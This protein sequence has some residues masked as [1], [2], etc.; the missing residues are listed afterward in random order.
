M[1][2]Q[3]SPQDLLPSCSSASAW[4]CC[5]QA[6]PQSHQHPRGEE[7]ILLVQ[8]SPLK[9]PYL[10]APWRELRYLLFPV[11]WGD[12]GLFLM[13][14]LAHSCRPCE[15][16]PKST[17]CCVLQVLYRSYFRISRMAFGGEKALFKILFIV[18]PRQKGDK[19]CQTMVPGFSGSSFL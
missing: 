17:L 18:D 5:P 13:L 3:Q 15:M 12:G 14:K 19:T 6:C 9:A 11:H 8:A 7:Q 4:V 16:L 2:S 1:Q 10:K